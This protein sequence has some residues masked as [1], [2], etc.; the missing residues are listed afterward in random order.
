MDSSENEKQIFWRWTHNEAKTADATKDTCFFLSLSSQ[1][2]S[3]IPSS[4]FTCL[5]FLSSAGE[6][7]NKQTNK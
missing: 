1:R 6:R 7:A 5:L 3:Y 2:T 4:A